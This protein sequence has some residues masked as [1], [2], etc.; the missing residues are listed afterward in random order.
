MKKLVLVLFLITLSVF[1]Y[2]A[3]LVPKTESIDVKSFSALPN[4]KISAWAPYWDEDT[5][6]QSIEKAGNK[7][8]HVLPFWYQINEGGEVEQYPTN[9]KKQILEVLKKKDITSIA[10]ITNDF[11]PERVSKILDDWNLWESQIDKITQIAINNNYIGIDLDWEQIDT[12]DAKGF[13][14]FVEDLAQR[15]HENSLLLSVT[16]HARSEHF[17]WAGAEAHD[18]ESLAKAADQI[19]IMAYDYHHAGSDPGPITPLDWYQDVLSYFVSRVPK[20]KLI[21]CL[22]NYGYQWSESGGKSIT[23]KE[24]KDISLIENKELTRDQLSSSLTTQFV[25]DEQVNTIWVEDALSINTKISIAQKNFGV[26]NF[27]LWKLGG[28]D[29]SFWENSN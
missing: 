28:E 15:L 4:I 11:D 2:K 8:D 12:D 16:V 25:K 29:L 22:P 24:A 17:V 10:S 27:C 14:E 21:V 19:R 6:L 5:V 3:S 1:L 20:E 18:T 9:K 23:Y 7:L 26:N 13:V